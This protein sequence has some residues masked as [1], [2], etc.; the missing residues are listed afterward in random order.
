MK[1][2]TVLFYYASLYLF[3]ACQHTEAQTIGDLKKL[4]SQQKARLV[5][6]SIAAILHFTGNQYNKVYAVIMD[7]AQK[8][9]PVMQSNDSRMSKGK[10]LKALFAEEEAKLKTVLTA[11]QY[12]LY[13]LKKQKAIAY[14]KK[15]WQEQKLVFNVSE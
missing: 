4:S 1:R 11:D 10:Q 2:L 15:H 5:A 7:G 6:D 14:Y 8:A 12:T 13:E 3:T 9:A